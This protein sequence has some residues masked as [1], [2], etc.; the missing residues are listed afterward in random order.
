MGRTVNQ[1]Y[2]E[3]CGL[4]FHTQKECKNNPKCPCCKSRNTDYEG[5]SLKIYLTGKRK[6]E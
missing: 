1:Y 6:K 5:S 4:V 3:D 2:C